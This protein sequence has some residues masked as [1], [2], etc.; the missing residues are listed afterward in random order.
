MERFFHRPD[1]HWRRLSGAL[2]FY[3]N[4]PLDGELPVNPH[5]SMNGAPINRVTPLPV[6]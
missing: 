6:H 1:T 4:P 5:Q 3:V 2:H